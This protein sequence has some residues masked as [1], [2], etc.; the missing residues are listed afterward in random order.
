[1]SQKSLNK[2]EQLIHRS[3]AMAR[4][5]K[6]QERRFR[7]SRLIL[8]PAWVL[9]AFYGTQAIIVVLIWALESA[10]VDIGS[11]TTRV[12]FETFLAATVYLLAFGIAFGVPY[13]IK[14]RRV[15]RAV[16]GLQRLMSWTDI[17]L[18]PVGFV[19]YIMLVTVL[20]AIAAQVVPGFTPDQVQDVG[21]KGLTNNTG[22]LL[23]FITLVIIAP[24]AEE[25]LFRGYLYGKLRAHVPVWAAVLATSLL[26]AL[27][28][29][30]WNVAVDTFALSIV[31]CGLRELTGSIWAGI[32]LHML[33]N[34][35]AFYILFIGPFMLFGL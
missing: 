19:A 4:P 17:G 27:V 29:G 31:M 33:K 10:G 7:W 15:D 11:F 25:T 6:Q 28:H 18:A 16:L 23:A 8:F 13:L 9:G 20:L 1:M 5:K 30:Q 26:F 34:A 3:G 35:I 32:L 21:F 12:V 14:K 22:Y 2:L 24:I